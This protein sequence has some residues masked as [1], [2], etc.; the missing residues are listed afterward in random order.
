MDGEERYN[1][2]EA[3]KK[4]KKQT[5]LTIDDLQNMDE[6]NL[7]EWLPILEQAADEADIGKVGVVQWNEPAEV[8][9]G[10]KEVHIDENTSNP[11]NLTMMHS[12]KIPI[13]TPYE[14][15]RSK[16]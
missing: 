8:G 15:Y 1:P 5:K 16:F 4:E 3:K 11:F 7:G 9:A 10:F 13:F 14:I 12:L 2:V 6:F